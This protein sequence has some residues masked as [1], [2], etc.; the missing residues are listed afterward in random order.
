MGFISLPLMRTLNYILLVTI[1]VFVIN[2]KAQ[3]KEE[4]LD[5]A[6]LVNF[7]DE[8]SFERKLD[9]NTSVR[10]NSAGYFKYEFQEIDVNDLSDNQLD[11]YQFIRDKYKSLL[12][13]E[14]T[15]EKFHLVL[16]P[17]I[18]TTEYL[19]KNAGVNATTLG[20]NISASWN[21][22]WYAK[23]G[24]SQRFESDLLTDTAYLNFNDTREMSESGSWYRGEDWRYCFGYFTRRFAI[25]F[26]NNRNR[27]GEGY[28]NTNIFSGNNP[29][30]PKIELLIK[31]AKWFEF[32]FFHGKMETLLGSYINDSVNS[33]TSVDQHKKY[34]AANLFTFK[35]LS[36]WHISVGNSIVYSE[37]SIKP[38]YLIPFMFYK[39]A[40]HTYNGV[41]NDTGQNAQMF[42]T[43]S[44]KYADWGRFY[45]SLFVDEITLSEVFSKDAN[46]NL[47][48]YKI[49]TK[50]YHL[51]PDV[52]A[53]IEYTH[54][55]PMAY[56]HYI[57][58]TNFET[59]GYNIGNPL[60]E[61][62]NEWYMSAIWS[63]SAKF[64][65]S[66]EYIRQKKG[67]ELVNAENDNRGRIFLENIEFENTIFNLTATYHFSK[68][69]TG[70]INTR[71]SNPKGKTSYLP[72]VYRNKG[73]V[74][75]LGVKY[76]L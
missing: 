1:N 37:N 9:K 62:A 22:K 59:A 35:P 27:W 2:V 25:S 42:L 73:M 55:R 68:K 17:A 71:V 20:L 23:L 49:G 66:F 15:S 21:V 16:N 51:F 30:F 36:Y 76:G 38:V 26:N 19:G 54:N 52:S 47:L 50:I 40:D 7:I 57:Y 10:N 53:I 67:P 4:P 75:S 12:F 41:R 33:E 70:N 69:I 6:T 39:S 14:S 11:K 72:A 29:R 60:E 13:P 5:N 28:H 65:A 46:S 63:P 34:I 64:G 56:T 18:Y 48:G 43:T 74:L 8:L 32:N 58:S 45:Y 3:F 44:L 61:N 31:P 24:Y